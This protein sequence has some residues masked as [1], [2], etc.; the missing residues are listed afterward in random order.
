MADIILK[1]I[2][3]WGND[4]FCVQDYKGY[5]DD[6]VALN[7]IEFNENEYIAG[8]ILYDSDNIDTLKA[9]YNLCQFERIPL[10]LV[11]FV[12]IKNANM[13][14]ELCNEFMSY[15]DYYDAYINLESYESKLALGLK[16]IHRRSYK[17]FL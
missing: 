9:F 1:K 6:N 8:I 16:A 14:I 13:A 12:N 17:S 11:E 5:L 4:S 2:K 7:I 15:V 3:D 10:I